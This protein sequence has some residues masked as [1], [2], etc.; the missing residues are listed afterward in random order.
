MPI[1]APERVLWKGLMQYT[2]MQRRL[3]TYFFG[4]SVIILHFL[5][6]TATRLLASNSRYDFPTSFPLRTGWVCNANTFAEK[7][8]LIYIN[9][10]TYIF[11]LHL[12]PSYQL[13]MIYS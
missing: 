9:V 6:Q 12:P 3:F 1:D 10:F 2:K 13:H 11:S 5:S 8:R 7:T 4:F